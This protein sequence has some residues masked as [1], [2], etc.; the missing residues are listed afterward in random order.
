MF[1]LIQVKIVCQNSYV[2]VNILTWFWT[3]FE[4]LSCREDTPLHVVM[5]DVVRCLAE[6]YKEKELQGND[7]N[8]DFILLSVFKITTLFSKLRVI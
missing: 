6:K 1:Y 7:I 4:G 8:D 3:G 5:V 2:T